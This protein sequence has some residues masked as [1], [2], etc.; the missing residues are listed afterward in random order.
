MSFTEQPHETSREVKMT[1]YL[2]ID[3]GLSGGLVFIVDDKIKYKIVMPTIST[4]TADGDKKTDLDRH[5]ILSFLTL[6]PA[7][8]HVVIEKQKAY[9]G[10]NISATGTTFKNYGIL[11][12][13]LTAAHFFITE[14]ESDVWQAF[15]GIVSVKKANGKTT[16]QQ[17]L[18]IVQKLFPGGD[19]RKSDR[20]YI[21]HDGIVD[22]ALLANY[23]Q[24]LFRSKDE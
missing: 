2:G 17:A 14:T 3:P 11:L 10:Q 5:G 18:P 21:A 1:G 15:Y 20:S 9:R 13:G 4:T 24:F 12:M 16:K 22:S 6:I 7:H 19:F 23:C 8:T